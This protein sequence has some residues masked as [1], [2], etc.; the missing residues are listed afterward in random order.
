MTELPMVY[1]V[2]N[3]S[4]A[5]V[6][7]VIY[8]P[9]DDSAYEIGWVLHKQFWGRGYADELTRCLIADAQRNG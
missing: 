9:Y 2:E 6:G 3:I 1:A 4:R 5:F 7:Y 8:H